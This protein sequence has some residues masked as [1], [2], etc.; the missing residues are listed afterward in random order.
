[1][2]KSNSDVD[3]VLSLFGE[4]EKASILVERL[5]ASLDEARDLAARLER[6]VL[7]KA[8][9]EPAAEEA[10]EAAELAKKLAAAEADRDEIM[11]LL[12]QAEQQRGRIMNLY[13]ATYQLHS[14]LDSEE[15]QGAVAE[16]AI[17]LLGAEKFVLLLRADADKPFEVALS[18]G[19]E[20]EELDASYAGGCFR[21]GDDLV[22]QTLEDGQLRFGPSD[23]S[24][25]VAVVPL[26]VLSEIVGALVILKLFD[27][28][29]ELLTEDRELLDLVAAHAASALLAAKVYSAKERKLRTLESLTQLLRA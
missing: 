11:N 16:I 15:V 28:K 26:Q 12:I 1:M 7:R 17:D 14:T 4:D 22:E 13:V 2:T 9:E 3:E 29:A 24:N 18:R 21:G 20:D 5:Q 6:Q 23:S 27:H 10:G 25:A 8:E 19:L